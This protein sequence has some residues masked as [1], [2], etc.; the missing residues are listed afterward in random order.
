MTG[1]DM[2]SLGQREMEAWLLRDGRVLEDPGHRGLIDS[3]DSAKV[4]DV[5]RTGVKTGLSGPRTAKS[6]AAW[7]MV[8]LNMFLRENKQINCLGN[9]LGPTQSVS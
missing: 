6:L 7:L 5:G 9:L 3:G 8:W 4:S 1:Q 2:F